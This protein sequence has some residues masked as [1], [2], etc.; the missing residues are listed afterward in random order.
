MPFVAVCPHCRVCR[1]RAPRSKRGQTIRCPKCSE[2]FQLIPE[3]VDNPSTDQS[4]PDE[5]E[6]SSSPSQPAD[7]QTHS[8]TSKDQSEELLPVAKI[9]LCLVAVTLLLSQLPYGRPA[10]L[11]VAVVGCF[12]AGLTLSELK[13]Q[14]ALLG[15]CG[16]TL[17]GLLTVVLIGY[18]ATL[19]LMTGWWSESRRETTE[20]V[21]NQWGDWID[22]GDA[23]WQ[24]GGVRVSVTFATIGGDPTS[25]AASGTKERSLW[26]GFK[27]T[28]VGV[29]DLDFSGWQG[30][31]ADGLKMATADGTVLANKQF[32]G[33]QGKPAIQPGR[34]LDCML[35]FE[36]PPS[37]QDLLLNL[38]TQSFGDTIIIR[39]RIPHNLVGRQ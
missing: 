28:N 7:S 12:A 30:K 23:G 3:R 20:I 17:N 36:I 9:A 31:G 5:L 15:W 16:L 10:A 35:A 27:I 34:S 21:E 8:F 19:G 14:Q 11:L 25:N 6:S 33:P 29:G 38:P 22:A 13:K 26:V 1:L 39:F 32:V 2:D 24:Q 18:P 4:N 37:G